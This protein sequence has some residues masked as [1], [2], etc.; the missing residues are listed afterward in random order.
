MKVSANQREKTTHVRIWFSLSMLIFVSLLHFLVKLITVNIILETFINSV[1]TGYIQNQRERET[2]HMRIWFSL[3]PLIFV[4]IRL[5]PSREKFITE[6][7]IPE[8]LINYETTEYPQNEKEIKTTHM[9]IWFSLSMLILVFVL[10]V[11]FPREIY[12]CECYP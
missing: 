1:I 4:L 2:T 10:Y 8:I 5:L 12:Y 7:V 3:C 11:T 9:R 6:N